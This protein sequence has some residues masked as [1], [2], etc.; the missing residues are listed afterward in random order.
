MKKQLKKLATMTAVGSLAFCMISCG[1][2]SGSGGGNSPTPPSPTVNHMQ[3]GNLG[4][5]P[6]NSEASGASYPLTLFN[7]TKNLIHVSSVKATGV[8]PRLQITSDSQ[9]FDYS[10]CRDIPANGSCNILV[11]ASALRVNNIGDNGQY[12]ISIDGATDTGV[13]YHEDQVISYEN[14]A[15]KNNLGTYYNTSAATTT[16]IAETTQMGVT[17]PVYFDKAYNNV[18]LVSP[19]LNGTLIGCG[20]V[21][22]DGTYNVSAKSSCSIML[23]FRGGRSI[24][25]EVQLLAN[26]TASVKSAQS[27]KSTKLSKSTKSSKSLTSGS[28]SIVNFGFVNIT[29]SVALMTT[30]IVTSSLP[31][32]NTTT[33]TVTFV[34]NGM[35]AA[36]AISLSLADTSNGYGP[37]SLS[38]TQTIGSSS[39]NVTANTC[40]SQAGGNGSGT[41]AASQSCFVT[42]TMN[43]SSQF[44]TANLIM[45]YSTG[46]GTSTTNYNTYY[47]PV[48]ALTNLS[49]SAAPSPTEFVNTSIGSQSKSITVTVTNNTP[50]QPIT[51]AILASNQAILKTAGSPSI[52]SGM[53]VSANTCTSGVILNSGTPSCSY[54]VTFDPTAVTSGQINNLYGIISGTYVNQGRTYQVSTALNLPYSVGE[55]TDLTTNPTQIQLTTNSGQPVYIPISITNT[56]G[57]GSGAINNITFDWNAIGLNDVTISSQSPSNCLTSLSYGST[58]SVV[59]VYSPSNPESSNGYVNLPVSYSGGQFNSDDIPTTYEAI[60]G[61]TNIQISNV[62]AS[63]VNSPPVGY[64]GAGTSV[65]PYTFYNYGNS[66]SLQIEYTNTGS[67]T[68]N[69]FMIDGST[70][71]SVANGWTVETGSTSCGINGNSINL[72]SNASCILELKA[73]NPNIANA[74]VTSNSLTFNFPNAT[75][76]ESGQTLVRNVW[77]YN[78]QSNVNVNSNQIL[79]A[80]YNIGNGVIESVTGVSYYVYPITLDN[81]ANV[82]QTAPISVLIDPSAFNTLTTPAGIGTSNTTPPVGTYSTS[83]AGGASVNSLYLWIPAN[84]TNLSSSYFSLNANW[85]YS[86]MTPSQSY[87]TASNSSLATGVVYNSSVGSQQISVGW[88]GNVNNAVANGGNILRS[89]GS[90]TVP[91]GN[92]ADLVQYQGYLYVLTTSGVYSYAV[93]PWVNNS[94]TMIPDSTANTG[95]GGLTVTSSGNSQTNGILGDVPGAIS[96]NSVSGVIY[97]LVTES[98]AQTSGSGW[99]YSVATVVN[100]VFSNTTGTFSGLTNN[101]AITSAAIGATGNIYVATNTNAVY[102]CGTVSAV[103]ACTAITPAGI[104]TAAAN[105][106]FVS[107]AVS[108]A[109]SNVAITQYVTDPNSTG[110]V[111][112][113]TKYAY[114]VDAGSS[115]TFIT[116]SVNTFEM[117]L[118]FSYYYNLDATS[119][120]ATQLLG[121]SGNVV[122][123]GGS[124]PYNHYVT[125]SGV[126]INLA[127]PSPSIF[128]SSFGIGN[129]AY[130][131]FLSI[132]G[133]N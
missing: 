109:G 51:L 36:T 93:T 96:V 80:N 108:V 22:A 78:G 39:L 24:T 113:A 14:F 6:T 82:G 79:S 94:G 75:Y 23:D 81:N 9:L 34:N 35:S 20:L 115:T 15:K 127:S 33:Q 65:S 99:P 118:P 68:A 27:S 3:V 17:I 129:T 89:I 86:G 58:C 41:V 103:T 91:S 13:T 1:S 4:A 111:T 83:L 104:A 49:S 10:G 61:N 55:A 102:S 31:T 121:L 72:A 120:A 64:T 76:Q 37:V 66:F 32:D 52:P 73:V 105:S 117:G 18:K 124:S 95:T 45:G 26:Y 110:Q 43:G 71:P 77:D 84:G 92:V 131:S 85:N 88:S 21:N 60:S 28:T 130:Y 16:N 50:T 67:A 101:D 112:P 128:S 116:S 5:I 54:T 12:G 87:A 100:G 8:D 19:N 63:D 70:L 38:S 74:L 119:N 2:S 125:G 106:T 56:N 98:G 107:L 59:F 126:S 57:L 47:Y 7:N 29:Q 53:T 97:A 48:S 11:K 122:G 123:Y 42:F 132:A 133:Q 69:N 40:T 90:V 46:V 30:G 114:G 25:S 44:G 62:I